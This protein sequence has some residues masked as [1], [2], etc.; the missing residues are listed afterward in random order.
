MSTF[1]AIGTHID[2]MMMNCLN[3][4]HNTMEA[5]LQRGGLTPAEQEE[6]RGLLYLL[7]KVR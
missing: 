4:E 2:M 3:L 6:R 7:K 5:E 1:T